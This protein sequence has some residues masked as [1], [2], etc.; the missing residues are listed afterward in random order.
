MKYYVVSLL[1][2][3]MLLF[4]ESCCE[5][6]K[7]DAHIML[8]YPKLEE[9]TFIYVKSIRE[10]DGQIDTVVGVHPQQISA[11]FSNT[12][13]MPIHEGNYLQRIYYSADNLY[14][15]TLTDVT[16]T[17]KDNCKQ[18]VENLQYYWNG[19][20]RTDKKIVIE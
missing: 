10:I 6:R 12:I 18:S 11:K 1:Y 20:L 5:N 7:E 15:D 19:Q 2:L 16:Y 13:K 3:I 17:R 9:G 14:S 4:L 8:Q